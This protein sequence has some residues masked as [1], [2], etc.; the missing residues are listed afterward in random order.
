V[1]VLV[2][3]DSD[4]ARMALAQRLWG[5]L[6]AADDVVGGAVL[7]YSATILGPRQMPDPADDTKTVAMFT[8]EVLT[9]NA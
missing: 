1:D 9:R 2:W 3:H 6:R 5:F 7:T 4:L 8:V